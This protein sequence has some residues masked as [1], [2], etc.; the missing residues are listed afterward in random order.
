MTSKDLCEKFNIMV[1]NAK[2]EL[3][4]NHD[5][6]L[7]IAVML[8]AQCTDKR[9]NLVTSNFFKTRSLYDISKM[10]IKD[11]EKE[12]Y[13]LGSYTKKARYIKEIAIKLLND[14]DGKVPNN[15]AYL[16]SLPGIGHKSCN[17]FLAEIFNIPTIAVDTHV[18]RV[19]KRLELVNA[20]DSIKEI[21]KKLEKKF[22]KKDY[23][24][25]NHQ[26]ILFGRYIC[27]A[28]KPECEKCLFK[29]KYK[30][31]RTNV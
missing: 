29:C 18:E 24:R 2:C 23:N 3:N 28:V 13:S 17:V 15:R 22:A 26:L 20:N 30:K 21:E 1:P 14:Y 7:L 12:I 11:I 5:Y 9:V 6:E 16:E 27:K 4:Y 31:I 19:S 10:E 25:V 8:S